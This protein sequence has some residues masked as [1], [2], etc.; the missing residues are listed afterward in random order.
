MTD[1][2]DAIERLRMLAA[3]RGNDHAGWYTS[4]DA[5]AICAHIDALTHE[6]A[7][8]AKVFHEILARAEKAERE[9]DT[10]VAA[11][12]QLDEHWEVMGDMVQTWSP[13]EKDKPPSAG[14]RWQD[15]P[16]YIFIQQRDGPSICQLD[17]PRAEYRRTGDVAGD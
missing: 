11:L 4:D 15:L 12:A 8:I 5:R 3:Y 1:A 14:I 6:D 10:A 16:H 13:S 7:N 17:W 2:Q 9:R